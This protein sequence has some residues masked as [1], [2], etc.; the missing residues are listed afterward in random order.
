MPDKV[1]LDQAEAFQ[2]DRANTAAVIQYSHGPTLVE[3]VDM[4]GACVNVVRKHETAP[5]PS[6]PW[7]GSRA[8]FSFLPS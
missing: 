8:W 2:L 4:F 7:F 1:K 3:N 5:C 6:L